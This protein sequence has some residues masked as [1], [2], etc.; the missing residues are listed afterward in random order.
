MRRV[1][2]PN[3]KLTPINK[4]NKHC[5][6]SRMLQKC[7]LEIVDLLSLQVSH[8]WFIM[9]ISFIYFLATPFLKLNLLPIHFS[10]INISNPEYTVSGMFLLLAHTL[11][12]FFLFTIGKPFLYVSL[13]AYHA[14]KFTDVD[15]KPTMRIPALPI[16]TDKNDMAISSWVFRAVRNFSFKSWDGS[17]WTAAG[18][19]LSQLRSA[20]ALTRV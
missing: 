1:F 20:L 6:F 7:I 13:T 8:L 12:L 10:Y 3:T 14:T 5:I 16:G 18:W 19:M 4:L 17:K 11:N 2:R 9:L 15:S